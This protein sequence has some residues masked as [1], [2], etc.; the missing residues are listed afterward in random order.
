[1][2]EREYPHLQDESQQLFQSYSPFLRWER[3]GGKWQKLDVTVARIW[4]P[5]PDSFWQ[6]RGCGVSDTRIQ[7]SETRQRLHTA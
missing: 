1:M 4:E 7:R 3:S 5:E 6:H 2:G